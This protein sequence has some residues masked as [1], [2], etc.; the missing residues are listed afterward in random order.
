MWFNPHVAF[1]VPTF[2]GMASLASP[3]MTPSQM[4]QDS[5]SYN[6]DAWSFNFLNSGLSGHQGK[7]FL[8]SGSNNEDKIMVKE[9][10]EKLSNNETARQIQP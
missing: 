8:E 1:Y 9:E 10:E 5:P 3:P 7:P 2:M 6:S 4:S